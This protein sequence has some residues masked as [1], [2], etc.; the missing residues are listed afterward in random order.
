[1][2]TR[3]TAQLI[4][5]LALSTLVLLA[6][7]SSVDAAPDQAPANRV[8][9]AS[10]YSTDK[11]RQLAARHERALRELDAHLYHCLPFL[12]VK[13]EGIG[14]Y[15]AKHLAGGDHRY[16]SLNVIIDQTPS[17]EFTDLA[18][19]ERAARMFSRYVAPLLRRMTREPVLVRD[20]QLDGFSIIVSWLKAM[21]GAGAERPVNET[22]AVFIPREVAGDFLAGRVAVGQLAQASHV[23][24]W[25]G[26]QS[27]GSIRLTTARE[28]DF[29]A[30]FKPANYEL[31]KGVTCP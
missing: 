22:I 12:E 1:M 4:L 26:E 9:P 25:D 27:L 24:A 6:V 7:A 23:L 18:R 13:R 8:L 2:K 10:Q 28:D 31:Q 11:A 5:L 15:K 17:P 20:A 29:V 3:R 14:F 19:E 30:T 21:P 16:L